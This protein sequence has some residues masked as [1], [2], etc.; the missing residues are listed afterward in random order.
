MTSVSAPPPDFPC[1]S[2][3]EL[4]ERKD[5][6][7][8]CPPPRVRQC[9]QREG[10]PHRAGITRCGAGRLRWISSSILHKPCNLSQ[11]TRPRPPLGRSDPLARLLPGSKAG[12]CTQYNALS[13]SPSHAGGRREEPLTQRDSQGPQV[14]E[15][16]SKYCCSPSILIVLGEKALSWT[17]TCQTSCSYRDT[18]LVTCSLPQKSIELL[19]NGQ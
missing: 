11:A 15:G 5:Q 14:L 12:T 10:V 13:L 8:H 7:R 19:R 3:R 9:W 6:Q 17:P 1:P 18:V 4:G 2:P 16:P